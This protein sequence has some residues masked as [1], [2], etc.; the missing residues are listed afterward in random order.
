VG[1]C[2]ALA[3]L[4]WG[5]EGARVADDGGQWGRRRSGEGV[6]SE[7]GKCSGKEVRQQVNKIIEW[8]LMC[9]EAQSGV[10]GAR[11]SWQRR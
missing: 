4:D 8:S 6:S 1:H 7:K 9:F 2:G 3:T 5:S 11:R 10:G